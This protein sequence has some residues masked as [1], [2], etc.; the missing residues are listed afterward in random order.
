VDTNKGTP[1]FMAHGTADQVVAYQY[2]QKSADFL[3]E[4]MG[5]KAVDFKS[6]P[7]MQHSACDEEL[8][9]TRSFLEKTLP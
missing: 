3:K 4:K 8:E 5:M 7:G 6:Y 1:V 9:A 2:G